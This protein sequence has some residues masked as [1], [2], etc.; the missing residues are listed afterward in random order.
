MH[1][2]QLYVNDIFDSLDAEIFIYKERNIY[3]KVY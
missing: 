3:E 2:T 1:N